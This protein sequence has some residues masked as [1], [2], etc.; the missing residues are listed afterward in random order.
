MHLCY[1]MRQLQRQLIVSTTDG[2]VVCFRGT[3][4]HRGRG[5][6]KNNHAVA[7]PCINF[8]LRVLCLVVNC[9]HEIRRAQ[10]EKRT[11]D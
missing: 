9:G 4:V 3:P 1:S 2:D 6:R 10:F 7:L 8:D 5:R 11:D